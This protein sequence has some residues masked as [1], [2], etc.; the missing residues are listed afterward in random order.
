MVIV[1]QPSTFIIRL[2]WSS[3]VSAVTSQLL[4]KTET[5]TGTDTDTRT[6]TKMKLHG[7]L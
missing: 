1:L 5:G 2:T 7:V 3:G 4:A 6:E